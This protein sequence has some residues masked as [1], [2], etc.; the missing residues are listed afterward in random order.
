MQYSFRPENWNIN[1]FTFFFPKNEYTVN[2]N[3]NSF[4][5]KVTSYLKFISKA[6][7]AATA[8]EKSDK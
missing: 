8:Q 2:K 7:D 1:A 6:K 4:T 5:G 3:H